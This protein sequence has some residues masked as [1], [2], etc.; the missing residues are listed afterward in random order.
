LNWEEKAG[1][2]GNPPCGIHPCR[3]THFFLHP[4]IRILLALLVLP[5]LAARAAAPTEPGLFAVF[6]TTHGDFTCRLFYEDAPMT[7]A[8]FVGLA[9]GSR[10]FLNLQ[11][12]GFVQRPFY[13]GLIFHRVIDGFMIQGGCPLGTGTGG[14]GYQF[15][16]EVRSDLVHERPG[17]LSMANSG[18]HT[19]GSQFFITLADTWW[20]DGKHSVFGEVIS[21]MNVVEA[22][23]IVPRDSNN[24]PNTPVVIQTIEIVRNG[25]AAQSF[26][27]RAQ[28]LP[29]IAAQ[30]PVLTNDAGWN[31]TYPRQ[32]YTEERIFSSDDLQTWAMQTL[33]FNFTA[34]ANNTVAAPNATGKDRHFFRV[35]TI[36]Y[37]FVRSSATGQ[38]V[39]L[40]FQSHA[41]HFILDCVLPPAQ[42]H[43]KQILGTGTFNGG[44]PSNLDYRWY[45]RRNHAEFLFILDG[46]VQID[47][48][49]RFT[50][51]TGGTFTGTVWSGNGFPVFG[52]FTLAP[53]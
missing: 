1:G 50:S 21:G 43:E 36:D 10:P 38:R 52:T 16:D 27:V 40:T 34:P 14:P 4:M 5:M 53:L 42:T 49:L 3:H 6:K 9:E 28:G 46:F 45:Q 47:V 20:L 8:N 22:I 17:L 32:R 26:N 41:F 37:G 51:E 48:F 19:N 25:A 29:P 18:P 2:L 11:G 23:G 13:D 39:D 12:G 44:A 15:W 31:L 24:R 35:A 7:V 33:P 30:R